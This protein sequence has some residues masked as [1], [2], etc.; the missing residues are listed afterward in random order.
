MLAEF[1][2]QHIKAAKDTK[3]A[4]AMAKKQG[5]VGEHGE[6]VAIASL[7]CAGEAGGVAAGSAVASEAGEV[8]AGSAVA[9]EAGEV[10]AVSAVARE[11]EQYAVWYKY[12]DIEDDGVGPPCPEP[13]GLVEPLG[14]HLNI[15]YRRAI[16]SP[17]RGGS[18]LLLPLRARARS[19]CPKCKKASMS[20]CAPKPFKHIDQKDPLPITKDAECGIQ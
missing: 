20:S 5:S 7:A 4:H 9:E 1:R 6:A 13:K 18:S 12:A 17:I 8:D 16:P 3:A 2:A 10:A 11:A 19:T 14:P 15:R